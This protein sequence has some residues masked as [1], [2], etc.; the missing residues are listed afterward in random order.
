MLVACQHTGIPTMKCSLLRLNYS[1]VNHGIFVA[2]N[3]FYS[4]R[5]PQKA[6]SAMHGT[7]YLCHS[8][9]FSIKLWHLFDNFVTTFLL[10]S[11]WLRYLTPPNKT[12]EFTE[13][14][15][16]STEFR[17]SQQTFEISTE[18]SQFDRTLHTEPIINVYQRRQKAHFYFTSPC[19]QNY[20]SKSNDFLILIVLSLGLELLQSSSFLHST[21]KIYLNQRI[22][23]THT[24]AGPKLTRMVNNWKVLE[25]H[26]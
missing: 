23:I 24:R 4:L 20:P 3:S 17:K 8:R 22:E 25:L 13:F 1:C 21:N 15:I 6:Y 19:L 7:V 14:S 9:K 5:P 12:W 26:F 2:F 10:A 16:H 11:V 18:L